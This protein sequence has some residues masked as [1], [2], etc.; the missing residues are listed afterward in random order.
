VTGRV[1]VLEQSLILLLWLKFQSVCPS[2]HFPP[3]GLV[4]MTVAEMEKATTA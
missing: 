3:G 2:K 4:L 1:I